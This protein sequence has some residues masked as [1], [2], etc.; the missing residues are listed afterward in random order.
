M[1]LRALA[2]SWGGEQTEYYRQSI[3]LNLN[4]T[5]LRSEAMVGVCGG[6]SLMWLAS[7]KANL[8]SQIF[9]TDTR[10][11]S[12]MFKYAQHAHLLGGNFRKGMSGL[13][14]TAK[15]FSLND[16]GT[17]YTD[18]RNIGELLTVPPLMYLLLS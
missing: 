3:G 7:Y 17:E 14:A 4:R 8:T 11:T 9:T 13:D 6:L 5:Q 2:E 10:Y 18:N 1:L 15:A 12:A 16:M